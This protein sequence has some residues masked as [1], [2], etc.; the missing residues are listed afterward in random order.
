MKKINA[1]FISG[2]GINKNIPVSF[3]K[4][5]FFSEASFDRMNKYTPTAYRKDIFL[6]K[7]PENATLIASAGYRYVFF[8]NGLAVSYG[9]RRSFVSYKEYDK[10]D[11]SAYVKEGRNSLAAIAFYSPSCDVESVREG[12]I[13]ELQ[14][15]S[16]E[17]EE[18]FITDKTWLFRPAD[19][20]NMSDL[21]LAGDTELQEHIDYSVYPY[22]WETEDL[23]K[24][25]CDCETAYSPYGWNYKADLGDYKPVSVLGP[26]GT[27]PW[28]NFSESQIPRSEELH[29]DPK[30]VWQG[31]DSGKMYNI[32]E[33]LA[34]SFGKE[35]KSGSA[36]DSKD[37]IY[38]NEKNNLFVF[39]FEKTRSVRPGII[40]NN[41]GGSGRIELYY[42][43]DIA[44]VPK[45]ARGFGR[46]FE[47]F[48]DSVALGEKDIKWK[49][50]SYKG[51]RF[52]TVRIAG[53]CKVSFSLI[54]DIVEYPFGKSLKPKI[55]NAILSKTWDIACNTIRSSTTDY[56]VD[57]CERENCLWTFDACVTGKAAYDAL[58]ETK[59]W[60][61]SL[62]AIARS[63]DQ[64]GVP[65]SLAMPGDRLTLLLDQNLLWVHYCLDYYKITEDIDFLREIYPALCRLLDYSAKFV[66]E[67]DMYIPP[68]YS[69]HWIDWAEINRRPYSLPAN[70]IFII[71]NDALSN[72]SD[73]LGNDAGL[74][75]YKAAAD[76]AR[77][78]CERF[79][80][81]K[82][83]AFL[84]H[85]EP[86][87]EIS[88]YNEFTFKKSSENEKY[89]YNIHANSL[90]I[91]AGIGN[92][93]M[94]K[95]A[96]EHI[97][98][99]LENDSASWMSLGFGYIDLLLSPLLEFGKGELVIKYLENTF[100]RYCEGNY[101]T[102]GESIGAGIYNTAHGWGS[103]VIS[104]IKKLI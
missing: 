3:R 91:I 49:S 10:V 89:A 58:G 57:T 69:W 61:R 73:I 93:D 14:V 41:M 9:P 25:P 13:A 28:I 66:D 8:I 37:E 19:W 67:D 80:D 88:E 70:A 55:D 6:N 18:S 59:M 104:L 62:L 71:A 1:Y 72:I 79:Y 63:I 53:N 87:H 47:G 68:K 75:K 60:R 2:Y 95:S 29:F 52:M 50:L 40:I 27:Y 81:F 85:I 24:I 26:V 30:C 33:N 11:V 5:V 46:N 100:K 38:S 99:M 31:C 82:K 74:K 42:S 20:Y 43:R 84:T 97:A 65:M 48:C 103:C 92:A 102:L 44:D 101:P 39:D 94:R 98:N 36:A 7:T 64:S 56:Y 35:E 51:F 12:F 4:D 34:I 23:P 96:S 15:K 32:S 22:G 78:A 83:C 45:V 76:K 86:P 77:C 54:C 17:A 21:R 16:A 90:A